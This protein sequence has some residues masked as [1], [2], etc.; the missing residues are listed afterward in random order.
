MAGARSGLDMS[1]GMARC[2]VAPKLGLTHAW[3]AC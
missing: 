2:D 1:G 3:G